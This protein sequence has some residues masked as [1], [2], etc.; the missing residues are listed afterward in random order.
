MYSF[1]KNQ[2]R[3]VYIFKIFIKI[4]IKIKIIF[5]LKSLYF[6]NGIP[7]LGPNYFEHTILYRQLSI[8]SD[9]QLLMN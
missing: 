7:F 2:K 9:A 1:N 8:V 4:K 6:V 5:Q 3:L